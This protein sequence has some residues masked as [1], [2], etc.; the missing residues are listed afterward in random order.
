MIYVLNF[1]SYLKNPKEYL[2]LIKKL[3]KINA[4]FWLAINP[5]FY[6][7]IY[8]YINKSKFKIGLQNLGPNIDKPQTGETVYN[9]Y[10]IN[11]ADFILLG[12]SERFKLGEN[13]KIII[14]K[15]RTLQDKRLKFFI[16]FSENSFKIPKNFSDV[17][18]ETEKNLKNY[19]KFVKAQNYN[20]ILFVYEP[21]WAISTESGLTPSKKFL[22]E[23]L[24][25]YKN[26]FNFPILYGGSY[27][28]LL[29]QQYKNLNFDGFVLG[30]SST[31]I[32]ELKKIVG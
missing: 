2:T 19:L 21:W 27:N 28:F 18:K 3:E 11:K 20:K 6:L 29:K 4:N 12:H 8:P 17:K 15:L 32:K 1:K 10:L 13:Q 5:Y 22:E 26:K 31:K 24:K 23:F 25:W 16:F 7:A 14:N 30:K 9:F